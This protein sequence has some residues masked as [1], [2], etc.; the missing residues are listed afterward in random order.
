MIKSANL[1][2]R[3]HQCD[4]ATTNVV[5]HPLF[6]LIP[7]LN[8]SSWPSHPNEPIASIYPHAILT[9]K[10]CYIHCCSFANFNRLI[11]HQPCS[12]KNFPLQGIGLEPEQLDHPKIHHNQAVYE[13]P[14]HLY[15]P[16]IIIVS[17]YPLVHLVQYPLVN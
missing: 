11:D 6:R 16:I 12:T 8:V 13:Q 1:M 4:T 5:G 14:F 15:I 2:G 17:P 3:P 7:T 9:A 10:S